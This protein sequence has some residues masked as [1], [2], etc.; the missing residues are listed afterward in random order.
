MDKEHKAKK[1]LR[2]VSNTQQLVYNNFNHNR[3]AL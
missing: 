1:S 3:Y 2:N